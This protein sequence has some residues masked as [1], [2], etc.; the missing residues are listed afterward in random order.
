MKAETAAPGS[1]KLSDA[2]LLPQTFCR[3][4][5]GLDSRGRLSHVIHLFLK[6]VCVGSAWDLLPTLIAHAQSSA[7]KIIAR[8]VA[9]ATTR[10]DTPRS[11]KK[12]QR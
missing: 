7:G 8:P 9:E 5:F 3:A 1:A 10:A 11:R 4:A 2:S 12:P 6:A